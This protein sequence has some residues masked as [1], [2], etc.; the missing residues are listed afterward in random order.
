MFKKSIILS[1]TLFFLITVITSLIKNKA[2]NLEKDISKLKK[3]VSLLEK[4]IS[5]AEIDFIYLSNPEK[6]SKHLTDLKK[7]EKYS[8]FD[9]SRIFFS[10]NHF[11][12]H[13]SKVSK[14]V[15]KKILK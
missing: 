10:I 13:D 4:Q 14:Y 3:E 6:L 11:L 15:N 7:E 1:I 12:K 8:T 5:D 9:H 2:R